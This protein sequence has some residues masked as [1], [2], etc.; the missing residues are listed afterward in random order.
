MPM[1]MIPACHKTSYTSTILVKSQKDQQRSKRLNQRPNIFELEFL[2]FLTCIGSFGY[3]RPHFGAFSKF[4]DQKGQKGRISKSNLKIINV[5]LF[6]PKSSVVSIFMI[7]INSSHPILIGQPK[8][9]DF[10]GQNLP[11]DCKNQKIIL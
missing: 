7:N 4:Q 1:Y 9:G 2:I 8:N 11:N 3:A 5:Q 6:L 10:K